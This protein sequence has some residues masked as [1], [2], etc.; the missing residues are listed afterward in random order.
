MKK[1]LIIQSFQNKNLLP[2]RYVFILTNLCS[3][4]AHS[5]LKEKE[6]IECQQKIGWN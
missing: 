5:V 2:H 1:T 6:L 3:W 4:L